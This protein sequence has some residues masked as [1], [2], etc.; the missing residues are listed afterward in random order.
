MTVYQAAP[1]ATEAMVISAT[2]GPLADA[3]VRQARV[4]WPL[5][6]K[7]LINTVYKGAGNV[8]HALEASARGASPRTPSP[9]RTTPCRS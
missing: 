8:P 3:K 6:R 2:K 4:V 5:D 7:G 9:R 1:F